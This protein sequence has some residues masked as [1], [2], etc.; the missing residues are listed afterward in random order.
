M[1]AP[2]GF[3]SSPQLALKLVRARK[4]RP[5]DPDERGAI[6]PSPPMG[7]RHREQAESPELA[8]ARDM[9]SRAEIKKRACRSGF[10]RPVDR[11]H[12]APGLNLIQPLLFV[13]IAQKEDPGFRDGDLLA[14]D[15]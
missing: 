13:G 10:P 14:R 4:G 8:R 7:P 11:G 3:L 2:L 1:I 6:R 5:V 15:G 9:R 12:L